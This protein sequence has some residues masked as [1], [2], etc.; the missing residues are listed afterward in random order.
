M[1]QFTAHSHTQGMSGVTQRASRLR[2]AATSCLAK[3]V[4]EFHR[5]AKF[6][7]ARK[8]RMDHRATASSSRALPIPRRYWGF[9]RAVPRDLSHYWRRVHA[10]FGRPRG[11][12]PRENEKCGPCGNRS[13]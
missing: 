6:K 12:G 8:R 11:R 1:G 13:Y 10:V 4:Y 2:W 7:F 9:A 3:A 5:V